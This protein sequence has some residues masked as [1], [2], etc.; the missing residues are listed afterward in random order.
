MSIFVVS[1]LLLPMIATS[2]APSSAE[3]IP[4]GGTLRVGYYH[5]VQSLTVGVDMCW[6]NMGCLLNLL[7]YD[8]TAAMGPYPKFEYVPRLC[9]KWEHS[10]D[11]RVWTMYLT[12]NA[13]WHDGMPVTADDLVFTAKYLPRLGWWNETDT[14]FV[15]VEKVDN[16]TV[17]LTL[18]RACAKPP[19]YWVPTLPKHIWWPYRYNLTYYPNTDAIGSGPFMLEDFKPGEYIV[20]KRYENY[21]GT[22][23]KTYLDRVIIIAYGTEEAEIMALKRGDI[24]MADDLTPAAAL[25]LNGTKDIE[26]IVAPGDGVYWLSFNFMTPGTLG[27]VIRDINFRRAVAYAI[28]KT[29]IIET[30]YLGYATPIDSLVYAELPEYN[31]NLPKYECDPEK[32]MEILNEAGYIDR[33]GDGIR[34]APDGTPL[35]FKI[36]IPQQWTL[37]LKTAQIIKDDLAEIGVKIDIEAIDEST[38]WSYAFCPAKSPYQMLVYEEIP[39]PDFTWVY[40]MFCS[41]EAGGAGNNMGGYSNKEYDRIFWEQEDTLDPEK[42]KQLLWRL[43]EIFA[44][45]LPAI[46]L[47]RPNIFGAYR[48]DK[49]EGWYYGL[50]GI[51]GYYDDWVFYSVHLKPGVVEEQPRPTKPTNYYWW[52]IGG[53]VA[54]VAATIVFLLVRGRFIKT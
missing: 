17:R 10:P 11:G 7:I 1:L 30:V 2:F 20:L 39:S 41:M 42:K 34:E 8:Q 47:V 18:R 36:G 48:T 53:A 13:T 38:W 54:A 15:K 22:G 46:P 23:R 4:I 25:A 28:N 51:W 16:Y 44:E 6:T 26:V 9:Y 32:A 49:F 21:H 45:D 5:M 52:I 3:E 33:D 12:H 40:Q 43:Q 35:R 14:N 24:D 31:P 50:N 27:D 37:T 19:M 29:K